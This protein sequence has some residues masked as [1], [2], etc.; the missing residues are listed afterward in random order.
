MIDQTIRTLI[1]NDATVSSLIATNAVYPQRL[2]QDVDKPAIVYRMMDGIDDLTAGSTSALT[3]YTM[4]L[5]VY[6]ETYGT[7][8]QIVQGL[9]NLFQGLATTESGDLITG[10]RVMNIVNDY[11]SFIELYSSTLDITLIVK[12]A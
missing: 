11:E 6:S 4:D 1:L 7:M 9:T 12:E 8:R 10:S 5:T 2:P 3:R